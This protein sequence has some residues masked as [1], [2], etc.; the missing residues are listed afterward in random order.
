M[1]PLSDRTGSVI[2]AEQFLKRLLDPKQT[3]R[4]PAKLREE[5]QNIL[6]KFPTISDLRDRFLHC[7]PRVG[8]RYM[9]ISFLDWIDAKV[10]NHKI[11]WF[12]DWVGMSD[13]WYDYEKDDYWT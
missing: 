10:L 8:P 1:N 4:V 12:C 7:C 6:L 5:A 3:P 11:T 13:C 2:R 9:W